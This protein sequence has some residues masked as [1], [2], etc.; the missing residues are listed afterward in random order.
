MMNM[1]TLAVLCG[2]LFLTLIEMGVNLY[3]NIIATPEM[4]EELANIMIIKGV[5]ILFQ[6][7]AIF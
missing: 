2:F 6:L 5:L 1:T 7:L 4:Y 3:L